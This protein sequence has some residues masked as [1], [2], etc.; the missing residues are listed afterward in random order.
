MT[1]IEIPLLLAGI[2]FLAIKQYDVDKR[3][4]RVAED[5]AEI[6]GILRA[7]REGDVKSTRISGID[8]DI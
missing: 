2:G 1:W 3:I 4:D 7:R 5:V 8:F 6:K